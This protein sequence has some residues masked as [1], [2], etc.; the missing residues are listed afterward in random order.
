MGNTHETSLHVEA[1]TLNNPIMHATAYRHIWNSVLKRSQQTNTL[2]METNERTSTKKCFP[3]V[4]I[5]VIDICIKH[6]KT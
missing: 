2:F 3:L 6:K 4:S 1:Q 5:L